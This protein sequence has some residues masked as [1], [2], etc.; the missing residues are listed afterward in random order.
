MAWFKVDDKLHRN[1]KPRKAGCEAMG[2]W[3]LA[4]SWAAH[5]LSDGFIPETVCAQW[6]PRYKKLGAALV[7]AGLWECGEK[8]GETGWFFHDWL[9]FQPSAAKVRKDR[10]EAKQRMRGLRAVQ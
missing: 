9:A 1:A 10:A 8:G 4:G 3:V 5:E 6:S 2:L 7:A